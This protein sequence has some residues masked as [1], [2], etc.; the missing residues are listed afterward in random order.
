M[1][2]NILYIF[3]FLVLVFQSCD[4]NPLPADTINCSPNQTD[5]DGECITNGVDDDI[6]CETSY[7]EITAEVV[8][9]NGCYE[10]DNYCYHLNDID[11]LIDL[12]IC[13][14]D[15]DETTSVFNMGNQIWDNGRL[16]GLNL[17]ND[18]INCLPLKIG[19]L[20]SLEDLDLR[21][22]NLTALPSTIGNLANLKDLDLRNNNLTALPSTIGNLTSLED[23]DLENNELSIIPETISN[24]DNLVIL[25]LSYNELAELPTSICEL[26]SECYI[27]V[28][29]NAL[30]EMFY[31]DCITYWGSQ[32]APNCDCNGVPN[33]NVFDG[34]NDNVCD[35]IDICPND[36]Y[37]DAD[38]DEICGDVDI[39]PNDYYNDADGDGLCADDDICPYDPLNECSGCTTGQYDYYIS[40]DNQSHNNSL[41][42][43]QPYIYYVDMWWSG[44]DLDVEISLNNNVA[45]RVYDSSCNLLADSNEYSPYCESSGCYNFLY[46]PIY[47]VEVYSPSGSSINYNIGF[48]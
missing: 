14:D 4:E 40:Y 43:G 17:Y 5:V 41:S 12:R 29:S 42:L 7:D 3:L 21:N 19:N 33:G 31:Y 2:I 34:D 28:Y 45:I 8:C 13:S 30:C 26:P 18:D 39:C 27:T 20:T 9:D 23:L 16:V 46:E 22:N 47:Y 25:D 36:Y 6:I 1:K 48:W 15:F 10:W 44:D 11:V 35:D 37:N 38:G 24:L 32:N